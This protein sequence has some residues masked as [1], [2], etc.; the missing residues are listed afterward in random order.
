MCFEE[1]TRD[2][3]DNEGVA[4][5]APQWRLHQIA[6]HLLER[7]ETRLGCSSNFVL[8]PLRERG[9]SKS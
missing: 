4:R 3:P 2:E 1:C 6:K 9:A 7:L 5:V 8:Q